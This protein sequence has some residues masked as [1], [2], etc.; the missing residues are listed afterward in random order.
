[1]RN[2]K[3]NDPNL[4]EVCVLIFKILEVFLYLKINLESLIVFFH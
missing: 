3:C 2:I 4:K 1:M